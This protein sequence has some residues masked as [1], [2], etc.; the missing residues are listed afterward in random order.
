MQPEQINDLAQKLEVLGINGYNALQTAYITRD[1]LQISYIIPW[2]VVVVVVYFYAKWLKKKHDKDFFSF[3]SELDEGRNI[4]LF[5]MAVC[6][7]ILAIAHSII[8][9]DGIRGV[10]MYLVNPD[11]HTT[12]NILE[13]LKE[14][15]N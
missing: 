10:I 8:I 2:M 3:L 5:I 15:K 7:L 11:S 4:F 14:V 6:A 13:T 12:Y 9:I 1:V